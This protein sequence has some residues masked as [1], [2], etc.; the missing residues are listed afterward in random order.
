[1]K[2]DYSPTHYNCRCSTKK[3]EKTRQVRI[4]VDLYYEMKLLAS[5]FDKDISEVSSEILNAGLEQFKMQNRFNLLK[6]IA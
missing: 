1:M 4:G 5:V 6:G 3:I 2:R